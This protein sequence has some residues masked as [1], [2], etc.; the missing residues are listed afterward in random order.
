MRVEETAIL[1]VGDGLFCL[2]KCACPCVEPCARH[3][4]N[5]DSALGL[6]PLA[7]AGLVGVI[8]RCQD[9]G[10][11]HLALSGSSS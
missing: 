3:I 5:R 8:I 7:L 6:R 4:D 1:N 10:F 11:E 2:K 9:K